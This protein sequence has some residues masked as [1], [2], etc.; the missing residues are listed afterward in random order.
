MDWTSVKDKLP[1]EGTWLCVVKFY[2]T[3]GTSSINVQIGMTTSIT[4]PDII[5][6]ECYFNP[7]RGWNLRFVPADARVLYWMPL[8]EIPK[9]EEI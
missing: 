8:P 6:M 2:T 4:S 9:K 5:L 7:E 3:L 1:Q